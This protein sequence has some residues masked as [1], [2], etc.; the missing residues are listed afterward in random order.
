MIA[1]LAI[2]VVLAVLLPP[3]INANR[4]RARLA[5]SVSGALGRNVT[6]GDVKIRLLPLPGFQIEN[7]VI[8]DDPA[9]SAEPMLR[10]ES[11]TARLR[12]TSLWRGRL[13][14]ARLSLS[15]PSLNLVRNEQGRWN[16]EGL[17]AHASQ[18][19]AAPTA[20]KQPES[21]PRFPYIE[22]DT[23]RINF[24]VLQE[25]KA[26]ALVEADFS[27]W[28]ESE[29]QWNMRLE[30]R[31]TRTD[32]NL[33]DTGTLR[34]QGSFQRADKL[35]NTPTKL[36]FD[37][38][39]SQLGQLTTLIYGRDRGWRG[40][41]RLS[42][43]LQGTP[44]EFAA[45]LS[46]QI[47]DFH[48]Y[49]IA[50]EDSVRLNAE[51]SAIHSF[52]SGSNNLGLR[53]SFNCDVP[54]GSG[55]LQLRSYGQYWSQVL[56]YL[57]V[58][59]ENVPLAPLAQL[60]RHAKR[61]VP[62]DITAD[63]T[64]NGYFSRVTYP[65][66]DS[67]RWIGQGTLTNV[68]LSSA[69]SAADLHVERVHFGFGQAARSPQNTNGSSLGARLRTANTASLPA[70]GSTFTLDPFSLDLGGAR[71][72]VI[73]GMNTPGG[74]HLDVKGESDTK[75][76]A[77]AAQLFGL[78]SPPA[79]AGVRSGAASVDLDIDERWEGFGAPSLTG[80]VRSTRPP[81]PHEPEIASKQQHAK[82]AKPFRP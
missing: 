21:R 55:N 50:S 26:H 39:K 66:A 19:S 80:P 28:Q 22:A 52:A 5:K 48:R 29:N 14:I 54:L 32:A 9:F 69:S 2:L 60:Y 24:K 38:R 67:P 42:G 40:D 10:A 18:V 41:V 56:S 23:G 12:L 30:A 25:K 61:N 74:L 33:G 16:I 43:T 65:D 49:D 27:L 57:S 6:M 58:R 71:P 17:L 77:A 36:T 11:V 4:L 72:L 78:Q 68:R 79:L 75:Q 46:V 64:F 35:E 51:C 8:A 63:G 73:S 70:S 13:E 15:Y 3:F 81:S 44:K 53:N 37:W 76:L 31:P 1:A 59:A 47:D 62:R 7:F 34:I 82:T 20:K 45:K